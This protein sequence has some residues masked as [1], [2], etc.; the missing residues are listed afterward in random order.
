MMCQGEMCL[1]RRT[2]ACGVVL[3]VLLLLSARQVSA[4]DAPA[5]ADAL[6]VWDTGAASAEA[7]TAAAL[8]E[9]KGWT[10]LEGAEAAPF[11]GDAVIA[12]GRLV[13]V[14]RR[15]GTG[16]EIY[17]VDG[18]GAAHLRTRLVPLTANG[19]PAARLEKV[20]LAELSETAASLAALFKT[21]KGMSLAMR[22]QLGRGTPFVEAELTEAPGRLRV[23]A[24]SRFAIL[25]DF[26]ADD[27]MLDARKVPPDVIAVPSENLIL[28]PTA[29]GRSIVLCVFQ[30]TDQDARLALAGTGDKRVIT[31]SDVSCEK[32]SKLWVAILEAS[33]H[34]W[35]AHE[36]NAEDDG[37]E[38][39]LDW[40]MPFPA[41]WRANFTLGNGLASS[42]DV[43][44]P[45]K[46]SSGYVKPG[47][48][49]NEDIKLDASR[50]RWVSMFGSFLYPCWI[51]HEGRGAIQP[52]AKPVRSKFQTYWPAFRGPVVIY[53][54][55]RVKSTPLDAYTVIDVLGNT[56]GKGPCE[57]ILDIEHQG[58]EKKGKPT[59]GTRSGLNQI[60]REGKQ[61]A[62]R[63]RIEY[64]LNEVIVFTGH[65]RDRIEHY[66]AFGRKMRT[67][68]EGQKKEHPELAVPIGKLAEI[69][70]ELDAR[71][72]ARLKQMNAPDRVKEMVA[73]FRA[74]LLDYEGPD[75]AKKVHDFGEALVAI[76]ESQDEF[77]AECRWAVKVLRQQ[78]G[79]AVA[80]DPRLAEIAAEIRARTQ[81]AMRNPAKY[82]APRL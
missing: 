22:L 7:Y 71:Y 59:C 16:P 19:E 38:I 66:V 13:L 47:W 42:W 5:P 27:I 52:I 31:G 62:S 79:L 53:P 54:F 82:E 28:L 33:G 23:E 24:A 49:G 36:V 30:D 75:A 51:D 80:M 76:G 21:A 61:K 74:K 78:A 43:L 37:Q 8:A 25:P 68:L 64:L 26:F 10:A 32:N 50:K 41:G 57:Y 67:Y 14:V 73:E 18:N 58:M 40:R 2:A 12:C 1:R 48:V 34:I 4:G 44:L 69:L 55:F 60:Y 9:K 70:D 72:K 45:A 56:L 63:D 35:H 17:A 6:S 11:H 81:E 65:I 29:E 20:A 3:L 77:V 15:Q 46:G 39:L